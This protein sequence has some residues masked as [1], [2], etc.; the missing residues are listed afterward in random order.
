MPP[1]MLCPCGLV[2]VGKTT[3]K[4]KQHISEHTSAIRWNDRDDPVAVQF[5]DAKHHTFQLYVFVA[6]KKSAHHVESVHDWLLKRCG[7]F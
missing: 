3:R 1:H 6:L 5:N 4:L 7:F 2:Y